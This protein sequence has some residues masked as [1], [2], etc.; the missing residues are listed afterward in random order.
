MVLNVLYIFGLPQE[1]LHKLQL[2]H[3]SAA[4]IIT[5]TLSFQ[6]I[7]PILQQ[8]HWLPGS[9]R[10]NYK[11]LLFAFMAIY[12][13]AP[14]YL[15]DLLQIATPAPS[16][17][18]PSS[19]ASLCPLPASAPW[20]AEISA[21]LLPNSDTT[22]HSS[23]DSLSIFK[24]RFKTHLFKVKLHCP[25]FSFPLFWFYPMQFHVFLLHHPCVS[26]RALINK[27]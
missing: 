26:Q 22:G 27:M 6:R 14:P 5:R 18:S 2:V 25:S 17:T 24:S 19:I 11:P 9:Q 7:T 16:L 13:L 23:I 4:W 3:N 20:V 10:I 15:S 1:P 21:A 12:N 8:L